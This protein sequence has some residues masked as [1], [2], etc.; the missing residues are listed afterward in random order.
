MAGSTKQN[1]KA[2]DET[3]AFDASSAFLRE[4]APKFSMTL[5]PNRSLSRSGF[6]KILAFTAFMLCIPLIPLLGTSVGM[7]LVPFLLGTVFLLWYFIR[8]N[9]RDGQLT[10]VVKLWDDLITVER[11]EPQGQRH[12]WHANPY[13]VR[14]QLYPEGRIENYLTLKGNGREIEL[15]AFLSPEERVMLRDDLERALRECR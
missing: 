14:L 5:W 12:R 2:G 13:W 7:A 1:A 3:S 9:Y 11:M 15:G 8:R 6:H 10:E 4:D